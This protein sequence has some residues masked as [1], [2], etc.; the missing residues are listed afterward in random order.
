MLCFR[1]ALTA[2]TISACRIASTDRRDGMEEDRPEEL[3]QCIWTVFRKPAGASLGTGCGQ[4]RVLLPACHAA[5]Q[6]I[7]F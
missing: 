7:L 6:H 5:K 4:N 3:F 2:A 1:P